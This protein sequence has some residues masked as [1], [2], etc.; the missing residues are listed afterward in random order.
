MAQYAIRPVPSR[1]NLLWTGVGAAL[2]AVFS[3]SS[4]TALASP[5]NLQDYAHLRAK[6]AAMQTGKGRYDPGAAAFSAYAAAIDADARRWYLALANAPAAD[7]TLWHDTGAGDGEFNTRVSFDRLR[8]MAIAYATDGSAYKGDTVLLSS[9]VSAL[10]W[11][12]AHRY[13]TTV[14]KSGNWWEWEIGMPLALLDTVVLLDGRL[15]ASLVAA[16]MAAIDRFTNDPSRQGGDAATGAAGITATAAN[17]VWKA[18]IVLLRAIVVEDAARIDLALSALA[19]TYP[20]VS[21]GDGFHADGSFIQHSSLAYTG[22]YGMSFLQ[23]A[24]AILYLLAGTPLARTPDSWADLRRRVT[25]AFEPV[26]YRGAMMDMTMGRTISRNYGQDLAI[27]EQVAAAVALLAQ[28]A[29]PADAVVF[30]SLVKYWISAH[31]AR[32]SVFAYD[33]LSPLSLNT[34]GLMAAIVADP[35]VPARGERP[36]TYAFPTMARMVHKRPGFAVAVAMS[37][38][39]VET[40]ESINQENL[41]GFYTGSGMTYLYNDDVG[42]Y[43]NDFWPTVD[44]YRLAGTTIDTRALPDGALHDQ[45]GASRVGGAALGEGGIAAMA[46]EAYG[47]ALTGKKAWFFFGD[48]ILCTGADITGTSTNAVE[49]IVENRKVG[50]AAGGDVTVCCDDPANSVLKTFGA[51]EILA[52]AHWVHIGGTGGYVIP[53]GVNPPLKAR[54][55][56][57]SGSWAAINNRAG[58]PT[59]RLT[60]SY[61]TLWLDHGPAPAQQTYAYVMMPGASAADT[62]AFSETP[63]ITLVENSGLAQSAHATFKDLALHAAAFWSAES[64]TS[65]PITADA[66][67]FVVIQESPAGIEI[68]LAD[69][70]GARTTDIVLTVAVAN[71]A[72]QTADSGI[73]AS[74]DAS[75]VTIRFNPTGSEGQSRTLRLQS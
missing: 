18:Q 52:G 3:T 20:D 5:P 10:R 36:G 39:R 71:S 72:I 24:A 75:S 17:R 55:E 8:L 74:R 19:S 23:R 29:P 61:V 26:M 30:K 15:D 21:S 59:D 48:Y 16:L 51:T 44:P 60:R 7:G 31:A 13:N 65:G 14:T 4:P 66:P 42:H 25:T 22:G 68:A 6:W 27:G 62:A 38:D 46:L 9:M 54:R 73:R 2:A 49:T 63:F 57:R 64:H 50:D 53:A 37:S 43:P 67:V 32:R 56:R 1:R 41:H 11:L 47:G 28:I 70:T 33:P 69:P 45:K 35:S 34:V 58:S 12:S 40:Y